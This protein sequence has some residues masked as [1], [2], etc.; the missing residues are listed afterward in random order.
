MVTY[1]G[2]AWILP[3]FII[4]HIIEEFVFPGGFML[5]YRKYKPAIASS[6]RPRFLI[7]VNGLLLLICI[8][9][10][11]MGRTFQGT[12]WWLCI[13]SILAVN[14]YFHIKATI[15][16]K[17][18]SPGLFTSVLLYIPLALYGNWFFISNRSVNW[19]TAVLCFLPGIGYHLFSAYNHKRRA[20]K[21]QND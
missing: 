19:I 2:L 3:V 21:F 6:L 1:E 15:V 8:N 4:L 12:V 11:S 9:P 5:W 13:T 16:S 14:A 10:I 17:T 18:Y 20:K 7:I